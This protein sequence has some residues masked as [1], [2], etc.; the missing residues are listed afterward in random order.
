MGTPRTADV[1]VFGTSHFVY[2]ILSFNCEYE[3]ETVI[4]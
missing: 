1:E 3:L 2:D 4:Y